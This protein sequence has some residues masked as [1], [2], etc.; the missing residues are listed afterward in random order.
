MEIKKY[1]VT[2]DFRIP[3][4]DEDGCITDDFI[5]V[6]KGKSFERSEEEGNIIGGEVRLDSDNTW[7]EITEYRFKKYFGEV[8]E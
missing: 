6:E 5:I 2:K 3:K 1:I 8:T 4:Y 7:L